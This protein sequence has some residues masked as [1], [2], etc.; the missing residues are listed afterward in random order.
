MVPIAAGRWYPIGVRVTTPAQPNYVTRAIEAAGWVTIFK[1]LRPILRP[2]GRPSGRSSFSARRCALLYNSDD[3]PVPCLR[4]ASS[5]DIW[6]QLASKVNTTQA[7]FWEV[8]ARSASASEPSGS[9]SALLLVTGWS[10]ADGVLGY[11]ENLLSMLRAFAEVI[12]TT[13]GQ[14]RIQTLYLA[15]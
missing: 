14:A 1:R 4:Y 6:D 8:N 15:T 10:H 5:P 11:G 3:R 12:S 7:W 9:N 13:D 2:D